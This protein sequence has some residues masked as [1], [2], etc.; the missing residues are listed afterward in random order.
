MDSSTH[1]EFS[2]YELAAKIIDLMRNRGLPKI[3]IQRL[4]FL[5]WKDAGIHASSKQIRRAMGY[6]GHDTNLFTREGVLKQYI[7]RAR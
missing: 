6:W 1:P 3:W 4:R 2:T 7:L 5:L